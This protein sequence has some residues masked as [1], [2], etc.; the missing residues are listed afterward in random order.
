MMK[1]LCSIRLCVCVWLCACVCMCYVYVHDYLGL[2]RR[3]NELME[4]YHSKAHIK[5]YLAYEKHECKM[6]NQNFL[7]YNTENRCMVQYFHRVA[8]HINILCWNKYEMVYGESLQA[9][10]NYSRIR[11][12]EW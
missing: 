8:I 3:I 4:N 2:F 6:Y 10:I 1:L 7:C 9:C 11:I 12:K 5:P